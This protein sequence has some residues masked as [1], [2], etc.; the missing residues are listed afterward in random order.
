MEYTV[1]E[2]GEVREIHL[3]GRFTFVD[4]VTFRDV[5]AS[6]G[7]KGAHRVVVDLGGVDFIDSSGLGMLM[8]VRDTARCN[9]VT[10][11]VRNPRGQVRKMLD[12]CHFS[13]ILPVET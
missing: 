4:D 3:K 11:V 9:R 12:V 6:F 10:A 1:S 2:R 5:L 8:L 13:E 7:G